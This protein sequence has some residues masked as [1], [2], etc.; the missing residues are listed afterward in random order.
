MK[1]KIL[2]WYCNGWDEPVVRVEEFA[3]LEAAL[4]RFEYW[5]R[6]YMAMPILAAI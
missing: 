5:N 4:I 6:D 2:Y 1:W 3:S